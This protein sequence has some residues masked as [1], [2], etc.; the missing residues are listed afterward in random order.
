MEIFCIIYLRIIISLKQ[1]VNGT[2]ILNITPLFHS[3]NHFTASSAPA[4]VIVIIPL[5]I[6]YAS[7]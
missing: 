5:T 6:M 3:T 2:Q 1:S 4:P 7:L